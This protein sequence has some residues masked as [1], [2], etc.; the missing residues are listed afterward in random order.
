MKKKRT[1]WLQ[2]KILPP[3]ATYFFLPLI[4]VILKTCT[5]TF[6]GSDV[7]FEQAKQK[8]CFLAFWHDAIAALVPILHQLKD[9]YSLQYTVVMSQSRDADVLAHITES[10][11]QAEAI[12]IRHSARHAA[13]KLIVDAASLGKVVLITPDGP[14]GPA[15]IVKP[16]VSFAA[17]QSQCP[18]IALTWTSS[19]YW[20]L[21]TWDKMRIP[22][23]FSSI[24]VHFE[25]PIFPQNFSQKELSNQLQ[26]AL[27]PIVTVQP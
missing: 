4:K 1:Y 20:S 17:K 25:K 14:K 7:F 18:I 2:K 26:K 22:K 11:P 12:R 27:I 6:S 5:I 3:L 19:K 9:A 13:T 15:K 24:Q 23:P 8:G 10:Y 21:P 16:G